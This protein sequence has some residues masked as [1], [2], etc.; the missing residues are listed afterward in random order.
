MKYLVRVYEVHSIDIQVDAESLERAKEI[1]NDMIEIG[2]NI[3]D[4]EYSYTMEPEDWEVW[5][6]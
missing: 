1:A 6:I 2:D 3:N 4:S 5:K